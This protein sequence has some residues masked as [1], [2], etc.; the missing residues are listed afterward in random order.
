V[1]DEVMDEEGLAKSGS[2][3]DGLALN[4][5]RCCPDVSLTARGSE[6]KGRGE[7]KSRGGQEG[8]EGS[9]GKEGRGSGR[10]K[11]KSG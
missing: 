8:R 6:K 2:P 1:T 3:K 5:Q 7:E 4:R 9:K 10:S 11:T